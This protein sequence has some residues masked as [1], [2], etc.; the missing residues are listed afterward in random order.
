LSMYVLLSVCIFLSIFFRVPSFK[1]RKYILYFLILFVGL[2]QLS[3]RATIIATLIIVVIIVPF[4]LLQGKKKL[5]F[6]L[7]SLF[8]SALI[9]III[10]QVTTI[11]KR[12]I[13]DLEN[14]LSEY[15]DPGDLTESRLARWNLELGLIQKS[16][17]LGYGTGSEKF[18]LKDTYFENKFYRSYLL[19]LNAH[20]QFLSFLLNAG[21]IGLFVF[22]YIYYYGLRVAIKRKDFLLLS[23][24]IILLIVSF[25]ENIL[26]VS[27][28]VLFYG[29]F[30]SFLL[31]ADSNKNLRIIN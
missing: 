2:V 17:F 8:F 12:Y 28:G 26:D 4:F 29:F 16:P 13:Y 11:K 14:D 15:R 22:L 27:K 31:L 1:K 10:T 30:F 5:I 7:S 6:F 20:N 21:L 3:S 19:G 24:L 18:V 23:F 9:F 25:S